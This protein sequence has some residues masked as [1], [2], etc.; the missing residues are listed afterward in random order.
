MLARSLAHTRTSGTLWKSSF[1]VHFVFQLLD[2]LLFRLSIIYIWVAL[3]RGYPT[4]RF[5]KSWLGYG[6]IVRWSCKWCSSWGIHRLIFI[7]S[8]STQ[9]R[10]IWHGRVMIHH[11]GRKGDFT[12]TYCPVVFSVCSSSSY[13]YKS[14]LRALNTEHQIQ[15]LP[16]NPREMSLIP[17]LLTKNI[18]ISTFSWKQAWKW[19]NKSLPKRENQLTQEILWHYLRTECVYICVLHGHWRVLVSCAQHIKYFGDDPWFKYV[20]PHPVA[21]QRQQSDWITQAWRW[22]TAKF[23]EFLFIYS[24]LEVGHFCRNLFYAGEYSLELTKEDLFDAVWSEKNKCETK[25]ADVKNIIA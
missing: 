6:L 21:R 10:H 5:W 11:R 23:G 4:L 18:L 19:Q 3:N 14:A 1:Q 24:C 16:S 9:V 15:I 22:K 2:S 17:L 12:S 8:R 7:P 20:F 25:Q 13:T